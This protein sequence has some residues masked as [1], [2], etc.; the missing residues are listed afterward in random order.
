M[1]GLDTAS[2]LDLEDALRESEREATF[3]AAHVQEHQGR[4]PEQFVAVA[5]ETGEVIAVASDLQDL[6]QSLRER[7]LTLSDVWSRF[8]PA[9]GHE[10]IL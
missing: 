1:S 2:L 4:Y 6:V 5:P 10:F 3:W 9:E 7:G 8:I